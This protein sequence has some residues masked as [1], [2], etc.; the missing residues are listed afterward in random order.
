MVPEL[1]SS[2]KNFW[3]DVP[4]SRPGTRWGQQKFS[5]AFGSETIEIHLASAKLN[6]NWFTKKMEYSVFSQ[7]LHEA[8]MGTQEIPLDFDPRTL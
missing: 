4:Y 2:G 8:K 7:S 5:D 1:K 6:D 3:S